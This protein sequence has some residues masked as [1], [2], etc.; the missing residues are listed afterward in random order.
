MN[1]I[2]ETS[3]RIVELLKQVELSDAEKVAS[4]SIAAELVA[5]KAVEPELLP[6]TASAV[7]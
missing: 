5:V 7:E 6:L 2:I 3:I 4:L 1:K